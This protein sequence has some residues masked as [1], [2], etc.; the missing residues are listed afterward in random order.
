VKRRRLR[1]WV[2]ALYFGHTQSALRFQ[3]VLLA[4]DILIIGFF[5]GSQ[6]FT[7]RWFWIAHA[8][9]A[10]F[11]ILDLS[12]RLFAYGTF[13]RWLKFPTTWVDLIVLATLALP[14]I[15]HNWG[16]LRI[17]RLWTLMHS[18]RFW[19]VLW[20]GRWDDTYVEDLTKAIATLVV[21]VFLA[22]GATQALFLGQHPELNDFL[23]AVYFVVTSLST[24]GYGDITLDSPLGRLFS[25]A[26]MISG[27]SLF[28]SVAQKVFA[29][30]TKIVRCAGCGLD[31]H[32]RDAKH[33]KTCGLELRRP[34]RR[35]TRAARG[36]LEGG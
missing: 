34:L 7:E 20:R 4:L 19:N 31:R 36:E 32:D 1:S 33:C 22:A 29:P 6:F 16:F 26:L 15:L 11:L 24:T 12:A 35:R 18:E 14:T 17:L 23:D 2:R 8:A 30:Q 10:A 28:F 13:R 9:I 27:I 5:I 21:F 25:I 3:G